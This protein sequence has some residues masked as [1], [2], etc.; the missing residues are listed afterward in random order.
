MQY[1]LEFLGLMTVF[2]IFLVVSGADFTA[3]MT[4]LGMGWF[5]DVSKFFTVKTIRDSFIASGK[6]FNRITGA[7]LVAFGFRLA[8]SRAAD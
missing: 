8:L 7:A 2:S 6:W 3:I 4:G 1:I 5:A